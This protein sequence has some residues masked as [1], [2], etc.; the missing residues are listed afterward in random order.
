MK[1][2]P[3]EDEP[4]RWFTPLKAVVKTCSRSVRKYPEFRAMKRK[5]VDNEPETR[6]EKKVKKEE[7]GDQI[8]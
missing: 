1:A 4:Q 3:E 8:N 5:L 7:T 6:I 2:E